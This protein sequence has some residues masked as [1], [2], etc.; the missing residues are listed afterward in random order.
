MTGLKNLST[1][2]WMDR[3]YV[4]NKFKISF[5]LI[6]DHENVVDRDRN[7]TRMAPSYA[8]LFIRNF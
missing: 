4:V 8:N 1:R 3:I 7:R 6:S 2:G 5:S